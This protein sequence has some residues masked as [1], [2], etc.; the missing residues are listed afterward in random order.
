MEV[1][2]MLKAFVLIGIA[3]FIWLCLIYKWGYYYGSHDHVEL[4]PLVLQVD[5]PSLYQ[6]D[7]FIQGITEFQP[8][9]RT[10]M[11]ALL[12][13]FSSQLEWA[14][15]IGHWLF[16]ILLI[17]GLYKINKV[18]HKSDLL[19]WLL[20]FVVLYVLYGRTLGGV[21]IYY[22]TFQ[23]SNIA[24]AL[25]VWAVYFWIKK[26]SA[27]SFALLA[28]MTVIQITAGLSLSFGII[29]AD[30]M[31]SVQKGT[32]ISWLRR[33]AVYL[34]ITL[35]FILAILVAR[36]VKQDIDHQSYF[37]ILFEFRHPHHFLLAS[38]SIRRVAL[39]LCFALISLPILWN[40]SPKLRNL[41]IVLSSATVIWTILVEVTN[42]PII[43]S[44]QLFKATVWL[45]P[46]AFLAIGIGLENLFNR[47][48][49]F[50]LNVKPAISLIILFALNI[51]FAWYLIDHPEQRQ[52]YERQWFGQYEN[53]LEV[54][55]ALRADGLLPENALVVQP[56]HFTAHKYFAKCSSWV[57]YKANIRHPEKVKEWYRRISFLYGDLMSVY[58]YENHANFAFT[59]MSPEMIDFLKEQGVTHMFNFKNHKIEGLTTIA[60]NERYVLL[61]L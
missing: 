25:G 42:N 49:D 11:V 48:R 32:W 58:P 28:F 4:L 59:Q 15:L 2:R 40:R 17:I 27:L 24:A 36:D 44:A 22:N 21:E 6:N 56:F 51:G 41:V 46:L 53:D 18:F 29:M 19:C 35:P 60:E 30:L 16:S 23:A 34:I 20:V 10:V 55:I 3:S 39:V 12:S 8:N 57:D 13:P 31:L 37:D 33:T 43:A 45:K 9:E 52:F 5:D 61:E 50:K 26:R 14:C 38:H 7:F 1:Q 47:V 54:D